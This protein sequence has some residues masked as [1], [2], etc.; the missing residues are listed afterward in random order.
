MKRCFTLLLALFLGYGLNA[1]NVLFTEDFEGGIPDGWTADTPWRSGTANSLSSQY[2]SIPA[3]STFVGVNDDAAGQGVSSNGM[4]VTPPIDLSE[5]A[6]AAL[7]FEGYFINGDYQGNETAKV[8]VSSDGGATW[9]EKISLAGVEDEWQSLFLSLGEYSG[10]TVWIAFEY[11]DG[12]SWNYGF[13]VDDVKITALPGHEVRLLDITTLR[14]HELNSDIAIKGSFRNLGAETLTSLTVNWSD[15][16]ET[17]SEEITGL[18]V[19]TGEDYNFTHS[20]PFVASEAITYDIDVWVSD[21]NGETDEDDSNNMAT[22][23]I[24]GVTFVPAKKVVIEE[25]TGGWCGWCPRGHVAMEYMRDNYPETFIGI[26]VHNRD[27][28]AVGPYDNGVNLSGYPG[29]NADRLILGGSVSNGL[30]VE[31][32]DELIKRISPIKPGVEAIYNPETRQAEI[33]VSAEFVT[34]LDDINYRLCAVIVED[35][36]TG[37]GSGYNQVNYYSYQSNNLPLV[38]A[39]HDWQAEPDPVPASDMVYM[40]VGRALLGGYNGLAGIIPSSVVAGDVITHTFEYTVPVVPVSY[41]PEHLRAVVLVLDGSTGEI[42]N[43]E[44]ADFEFLINSSKEQFANELVDI[45][46][47]PT[48]G[49]LSINVRLDE[50]ADIQLQVYNMLGQQ[51]AGQYFG[52]HNGSAT[53]PFD[54]AQLA[55]GAYTFHLSM[56][57]KVA[58]KRVIVE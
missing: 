34:K 20:T 36:V 37:S 32:H 4:L 57:D 56:G 10:D 2:F 24:S 46:P 55:P 5:V 14:Y 15:G 38:G 27:A 35:S 52:R 31:Y 21:P 50:A 48:R 18:N 58:V 41:D 40:D 42:L 26:A 33:N 45:F 44:Q 11:R 7:T 43:A 8:L 29:C 1:Q 3:H 12:G 19:A 9:T 6:G 17:Y 16:V 22:A 47:N 53:L 30:F 39:G 51:V 49:E 54:G 23:K 13:C 25:G 28:M